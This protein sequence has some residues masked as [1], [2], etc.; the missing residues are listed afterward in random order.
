VL[1]SNY[2]ESATVTVKDKEY[3]ETLWVFF[4]GSDALAAWLCLQDT[5]MY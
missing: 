5:Q 3:S 4:T 2:F 1:I